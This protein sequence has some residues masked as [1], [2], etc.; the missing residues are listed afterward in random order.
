M[1][2]KQRASFSYKRLGQLLHIIG[3]GGVAVFL[4]VFYIPLIFRGGVSAI[5]TGG[6]GVLIGLAIG[7]S[8]GYLIGAGKT[9]MINFENDDSVVDDGSLLKKANGKGNRCWSLI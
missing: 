7:L 9:I 4:S 2:T 5:S 6:W 1:T 3:Y 8:F